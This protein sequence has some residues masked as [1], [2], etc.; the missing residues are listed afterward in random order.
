VIISP[1]QAREAQ[2]LNAHLRVVQVSNAGHSIRRGNF[3][4]YMAAARAFLTDTTS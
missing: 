4:D 1:E 2:A 3:E